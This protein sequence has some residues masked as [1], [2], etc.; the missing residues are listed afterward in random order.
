M[1]TITTLSKFAPA[2]ACAFGK[3]GTASITIPM[4]IM[5]T[6]K[7][8]LKAR[9]LLQSQTRTCGVAG[10]DLPILFLFSF[11]TFLHDLGQDH[12]GPSRTVCSLCRTRTRLFVSEF[13]GKNYY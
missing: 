5:A 3:A 9:I 10:A 13:F 8:V 11:S 6:S 12:C 4:I 1:A 7:C 2:A